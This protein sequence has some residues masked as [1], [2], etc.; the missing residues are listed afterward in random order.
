MPDCKCGAEIEF[1]RMTTGAQM[2]YRPDS[3]V[4]MLV[5]FQK[6]EKVY[7]KIVTVWEPHFYD[8]PHAK[9]FS[10]RGDAK[11]ETRD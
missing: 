5:R 2:P 7:G 11:T 9:E 8:C 4:K 3:A 6:G 10:G 1:I